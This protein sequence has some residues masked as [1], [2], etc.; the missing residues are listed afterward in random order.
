MKLAA[1]LGLVLSVERAAY[2]SD[3]LLQLINGGKSHAC[4]P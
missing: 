1:I 2:A 3:L 4:N